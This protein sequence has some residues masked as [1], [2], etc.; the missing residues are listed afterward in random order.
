[1]DDQELLAQ[2]L[3]LVRWADRRSAVLVLADR[4]PGSGRRQ[5]YSFT[6]HSIP[7]DSTF[8]RYIVA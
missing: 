5:R 4:H 3:F 1:V 6:H 2:S 8:A 7:I